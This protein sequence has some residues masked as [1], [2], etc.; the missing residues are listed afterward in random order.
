MARI[1]E[2]EVDVDVALVERLLKAQHP[3]LAGL[4]MAIAANGWD[5][6][7]VRLGDDLA[8]RVPRRA[9]AAALIEHEQLALPRIADR[10]PITVPLPVRAGR[11]TAFFPWPW[12]VVPWIEGEPATLITPERRDAWGAE[13]A[14]VMIALHQPADSDA[15]HN[16][17]RG[18]G[19]QQR[20]ETFFERLRT[21]DI[22]RADEL[23]AV[24]ERGVEAA[25]FAGRPVWVHGD[26]HPHNLIVREA[27]LVAVVD[28]GDVTAGDPASDLAT[29]WLTFTPAGRD[30]FTRRYTAATGTDAATWDRARAWAAHL[31]CV[32]LAHNDDA[33]ALAAIGRHTVEQ[34]LGER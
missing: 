5:N 6:A 20:A 18:T 11:P 22:A 7:M 1:P 33:P 30:A 8:V 25:P 9:V 31:A 34:V 28:F 21:H 17:V 32:L 12:S 16:P 19:P 13:L 23:R 24:F 3:D 4:P 2:A 29:A 27:D 14:D 15:P 26:P 10:L